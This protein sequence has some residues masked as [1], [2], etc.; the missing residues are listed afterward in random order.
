MKRLE[1][2]SSVSTIVSADPSFRVAAR[3][4]GGDVRRDRAES[5]RE[6]HLQAVRV[7]VEC[8]DALQLE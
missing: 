1:S 4:A 5:F 3:A 8:V 6:E 7:Q 2:D